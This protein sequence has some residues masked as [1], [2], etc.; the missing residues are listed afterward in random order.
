MPMDDPGSVIGTVVLVLL[1]LAAA[2]YTTKFLS[3][4]N[5][6]LARGRR[7][8][9]IERLQLARDKQVL[10]LRADGRY[11]VVG[12]TNQSMNLLGELAQEGYSGQAQ[13][14]YSSPAQ[15]EGKDTAAS[16]PRPEGALQQ[17]KGILKHAFTAQD[18]LRQAR[19]AAEHGGPA[20]TDSGGM[21][22]AQDA[23]GETSAEQNTN[24]G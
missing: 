24:A 14:G 7:L 5:R 13:E 22:N 23:Q 3:G 19:A 11:L 21:A 16:V 17:F 10:L 18:R 8:D 4:Q 15:E 1:V 6:R 9:V 12:V 20:G 2:Y